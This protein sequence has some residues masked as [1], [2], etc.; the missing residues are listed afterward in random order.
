VTPVG[1][2]NPPGPLKLLGLNEKTGKKT[3]FLI[4]LK[5]TD[6][7]IVAHFVTSWAPTLANHSSARIDPERPRVLL[8][9]TMQQGSAMLMGVWGA[10]FLASVASQPKP[11]EDT[12][13]TRRLQPAEAANPPC[14]NDGDCYET[15]EWRC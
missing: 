4:L 7:L 15:A 6:F 2:Q 3:D 5:K 14:E 9:P 10:L 8:T 1:Q 11:G 13:E 12:K